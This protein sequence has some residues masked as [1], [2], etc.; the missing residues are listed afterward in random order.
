MPLS[1]NARGALWMTLSMA[2]FV[3]NDTFMKSVAGEVPLFQAIFVRGLIATA[4]IGALAWQRGALAHIPRGGDRRLILYRMAG[5]I[6]GTSLFLTALF[7]MPLANATAIIQAAPLTV[8]LAAAVFLRHPVGWRRYTAIGVGFVGVLLIVRPG[9]EGFN[10]HS[11]AALGSVLF[12]TLRDVATRGLSVTMPGLLVTVLTSVAITSFAGAVTVF[13]DWQ[14][15]RWE[16]LGRL[17]CAAVL[18]LLGYYAGIAAMREGEIGFVS[19]FRYSNLLWALL[20]GFAVFGDVP[21]WLTLA[22]AAIVM[23]TGLYTLHRERVTARRI[24]RQAA[25]RTER[26]GSPATA[27]PASAASGDGGR[28]AAPARREPR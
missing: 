19:P 11:L 1:E 21:S 15:V 16:V 2:G 20:L 27:S 6:G 12:I 26:R 17:G 10:A 3:L 24:A 14:P 25:P 4:L 8:T 5:E 23:G 13:E 7:N 22:G 18:L 9:G 28:P